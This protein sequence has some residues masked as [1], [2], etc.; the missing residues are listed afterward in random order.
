MNLEIFK[1]NITVNNGEVSLVQGRAISA[2]VQPPKAGPSAVSK[3]CGISILSKKGWIL[4]RSETTGT[5]K[6]R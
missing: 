4:R 1:V 6:N 5:H 3:Y 2:G